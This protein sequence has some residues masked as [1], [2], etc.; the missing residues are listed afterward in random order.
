MAPGLA[1]IFQVSKPSSCRRGSHGTAEAMLAESLIVE[2]ESFRGETRRDLDVVGRRKFVTELQTLAMG[3]VVNDE[4]VGEPGI[5][6]G[7]GG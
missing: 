1:S 2:K 4:K 6:R 7:Y 5:E 3:L